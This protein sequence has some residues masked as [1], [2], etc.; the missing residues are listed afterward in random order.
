MAWVNRGRR[1]ARS[2]RTL[3]L[4]VNWSATVQSLGW[5]ELF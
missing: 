5:A 2:P 1:L 3:G 4:E